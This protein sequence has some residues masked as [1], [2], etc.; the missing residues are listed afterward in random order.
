MLTKI[1]LFLKGPHHKNFLS[2]KFLNFGGPYG[3]F[4]KWTFINVQFYF[5]DFQIGVKIERFIHFWEKW[6]KIL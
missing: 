5:L 2:H 1:K 3:T 4:Q 6:S